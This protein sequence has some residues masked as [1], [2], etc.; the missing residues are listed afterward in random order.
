M[1][2]YYSNRGVEQTG[3]KCLQKIDANET[4]NNV[5]KLLEP[6]IET[7]AQYKAEKIQEE[8]NKQNTEEKAEEVKEEKEVKEDNKE[9][10]TISA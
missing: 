9:A 8:M 3:K 10:P 5:Y 6:H 2:K 4:I 7:L 1:E